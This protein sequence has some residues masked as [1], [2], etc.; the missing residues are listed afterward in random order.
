M[1]EWKGEVLKES[2][3]VDGVRWKCDGL[4]ERQ[5]KEITSLR[6]GDVKYMI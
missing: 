1:W 5:S 4:H 2:D 6:T 3:C